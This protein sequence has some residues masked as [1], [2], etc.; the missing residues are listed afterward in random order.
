M[1]VISPATVSS[2]TG[3]LRTG[4]RGAG[5]THEER[6]EDQG[7]HVADP[8]PLG[9]DHSLQ[10]ILRHEGVH[11]PSQRLLRRFRGHFRRAGLLFGDVTGKAGFDAGLGGGVQSLTGLHHVHRNQAKRDPDGHVQAEQRKRAAGQRP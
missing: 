2:A 6:E 7:Q 9:P 5:G 3:L 4:Q 1:L 11:Q 10:Q 8:A